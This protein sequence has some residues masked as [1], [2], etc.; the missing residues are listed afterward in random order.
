MKTMAELVLSPTTNAPSVAKNTQC[1][2]QSSS[3]ARRLTP[4][5]SGTSVMLLRLNLPLASALTR[6]AWSL[7]LTMAAASRTRTAARR[8]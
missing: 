6:R 1:S 8:P 7:F 3:V 5:P 4:L 2:A